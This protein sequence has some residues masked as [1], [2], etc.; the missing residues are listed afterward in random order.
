MEIA[1]L[2][3][4]V[5]IPAQAGTHIPEASACS[6]M[7]PRLRGDDSDRVSADQLRS[8]TPSSRARGRIF[9]RQLRRRYGFRTL[10]GHLEPRLSSP[11]ALE[12]VAHGNA[13]PAEPLALEL[14]HVAVH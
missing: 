6:T 4:A 11:C 14:D 5:V 12:R 13:Q 10:V 1:S 2:T 3:G 8:A 9:P 7:G